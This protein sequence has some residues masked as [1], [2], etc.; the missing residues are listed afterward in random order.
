MAGSPTVRCTWPRGLVA[1]CTRPTEEARDRLL[2]H[3]GQRRAEG[4]RGAPVGLCRCSGPFP[5]APQLALCQAPQIPE[6][7]P[8][9]LREARDKVISSRTH[10][11][12]S[13]AVPPFQK[14][15]GSLPEFQAG[16]DSAWG[17]GGLDGG[18]ARCPE[19]GAA[20]CCPSKGCESVSRGCLGW[21]LGSYRR[22]REE[23]SLPPYFP[24][25]FLFSTQ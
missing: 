20:A 3:R 12:G 18:S 16:G 7:S 17:G 6:G 1:V 9:R 11:G 2:R 13:L 21:G 25:F 24:H 15:G 5:R 10:E 19:P 23:T 22:P 4:P 8:G 14:L